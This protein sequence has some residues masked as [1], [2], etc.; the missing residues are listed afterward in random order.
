[1]RDISIYHTNAGSHKL[2]MPNSVNRQWKRR[3][4][5]ARGE[6][7]PAGRGGLGGDRAELQREPFDDFETVKANCGRGVRSYEAVSREAWRLRRL[8]S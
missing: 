7:K 3:R 1:M 4:S 6:M 8:A 2:A 5:P